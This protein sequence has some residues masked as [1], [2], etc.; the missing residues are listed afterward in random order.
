LL[1]ILIGGIYGVICAL[2]LDL[3]DGKKSPQSHEDT[4]KTG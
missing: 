2:L 4:E 1:A 3:I